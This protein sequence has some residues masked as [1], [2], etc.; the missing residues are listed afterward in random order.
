MCLPLGEQTL[1]KTI[2]EAAL[3]AVEVA[4]ATVELDSVERAMAA[5]TAEASRLAA[6]QSELVRAQARVGELDVRVVELTAEL[7]RRNDFLRRSKEKV[8]SLDAERNTLREH[9]AQLLAPLLPAPSPAE[10]ADAQT[11]VE[12]SGASPS[13]GRAG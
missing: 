11:P 6:V 1:M 5:K 3:E 7:E 4:R 9:V 13:G 10:A 8:V 12:T 2:E